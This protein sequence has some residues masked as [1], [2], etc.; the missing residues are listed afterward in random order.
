MSTATRLDVLQVSTGDR[1]GGAERVA[2]NLFAALRARGHRSAMAVGFRRN[3]DA[4]VRLIS[5]RGNPWVRAW[6]GAIASGL[7]RYPEARAAAAAVRAARMLASPGALLDALRGAE[8]FRHPGTRELA[9][10]SAPDIL[11][12]HNLHGGYFDLRELPRLTRRQPT[13]AT[14]HDAWMWTGHCSYTLGCDRWRHGCGHCPHLDT[15]PSLLRDGTA[16][17][18]ERKQALYRDTRLHLAAPSRWLLDQV[19]H[20]M[21]APAMIEGRV[22]RNGIDLEVFQPASRNA[23][24]GPLGIDPDA[25]VVTFAANRYRNRRSW[26]DWPTVREAVRLAGEALSERTVHLFAIG[27]DAD[28]TE[29]LGR[30][31]AHFIPHTDAPDELAPYMQAAD[32]VV[33]A[34]RPEAE[35]GSL[36]VLEALACGKPVIATAVGGVPEHIR[37]TS[38]GDDPTVAKLNPTDFAQAD[39]TL[40]PPADPRRMA[41][42]IVALATRPDALEVMGRNAAR[43]AAAEYGLEGQVKAYVDWYREILSRPH[44]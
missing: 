22:I 6:G 24:R 14:L 44:A 29:S 16:A 3:D 9:A 5:S 18:W 10:G 1:G 2:W 15:Y 33:H 32:V 8:N 13:V 23:L 34:A 35:N 30:V 41:D 11:H 43:R 37:G 42:A 25:V 39:G 38:L 28:P 21:L 27:D 19:D 26:K 17:N 40:V 12:L 31:R 7:R 4:D 20:S 36:V